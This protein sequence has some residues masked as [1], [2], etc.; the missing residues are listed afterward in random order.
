MLKCIGL[1][2]MAKVFADKTPQDEN[3]KKF[4]LL[5]NE[6]LSFQTAVYFEGESPQTISF[7]IGGGLEGYLDAYIVEAIPS[8]MTSYH[9]S[10]DYYLDKNPGLF[11][12]LLR[13]LVA[14]FKL[15]ANKWASLW[16]E[17]DPKG[18]LEAGDYRVEID[19]ATQDGSKCMS[20]VELEIIDALL[21]KQ[22]L[23]HTNWFHTDCLATW[24]LVYVF[25]EEF[26]KIVENYV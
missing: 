18:E 20:A 13:P 16:F 19:F 26:W 22:R 25:S 1:S 12:D 11:P 5:K 4:Y 21:P 2:S 3:V 17:L 6:R 7:E 10:D 9:D 23:V 24:Y 14:D 15:D 8:Q